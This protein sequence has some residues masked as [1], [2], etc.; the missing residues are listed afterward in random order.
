MR[1]PASNHRH[2]DWV[3]SCCLIS[4]LIVSRVVNDKCVLRC[5]VAYALGCVD[6]GDNGWHVF[7]KHET[8]SIGHVM[9]QTLKA[10]DRAFK[11]PCPQPQ[12]CLP[13]QEL[14]S[15]H[16]IAIAMA[17]AAAFFAADLQFTTAYCICVLTEFCMYPYPYASSLSRPVWVQIAGRRCAFWA[18]GSI[19]AESSLVQASPS[20]AGDCCWYCTTDTWKECMGLVRS[21]KRTSD[22]SQIHSLH[23]CSATRWSCDSRHQ[24]TLAPFVTDLFAALARLSTRCKM[25]TSVLTERLTKDCEPISS[26]NHK[27]IYVYIVW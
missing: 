24:Y 11:V 4:F 5:A 12:R 10:G 6:C 3:G 17:L 13:G 9:L 1:V 19:L 25:Y 23:I 22:L 7:E 8:E 14:Q 15:L 18:L 27:H 20:I 21:C 16:R 2:P 26:F